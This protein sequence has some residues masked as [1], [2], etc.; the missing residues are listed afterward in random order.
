[1]KNIVRNLIV[2]GCAGSSAFA[3]PFLAIGNNAELFLTGTAGVRYDDNILLAPHS[4]PNKMDDVIVQLVPGLALEFGKDS[5]VKGSFTAQ[6]SLNNYIDHSEFNTQ[7][8]EVAFNSSYDNGKLKLASDASFS[9]LDQNTYAANGTTL[10]RDVTTAGLSGEYAISE[11]TS[12]GAG[13]SYSNINYLKGSGIDET[14]YSVPLNVYY[15]ITP[16]IDLSTGVTY[17]LIDLN[18]GTQYNVYYYNV[19][20]RGEFTPKLKGH[21][22]IGY[23]DRNGSGVNAPDNSGLGFKSGLEY[24][25]SE[26]TTF[27]FDANREFGV[28]ASGFASE[29]TSFVLGAQTAFSPSWQANAGLTYRTIDYKSPVGPT[30][31]GPSTTDYVEAS[32]GVTYVINTNLS[33]TGSYV[34]RCNDSDF[35]GQGFVNNVVALSITGRY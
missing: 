30:T 28:G 1:M 29:E 22:T 8:G 7:L 9:Q 6:E 12:L 10:R 20:A 26:K 19:G 24:L 17:T 4:S 32:A 5:L 3:A 33:V 21:F 16:K 14:D 11:K 2:L 34:Y 35:S 27:T 15:G 31:N 18:D 23:N 25:Y 13:F